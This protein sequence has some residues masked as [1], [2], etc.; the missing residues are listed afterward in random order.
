MTRVLA[1]LIA[2]ALAAPAWGQSARRPAVPPEAPRILSDI[3]SWTGVNGGRRD[4]VHTGIDIGGPDGQPIIAAADGVVLEA[5]VERC[6]GPTVAVDH[7]RAR[8]GTRLITLYGHVDQ[9]L[10]QAG[11]RVRRGQEIARLGN[12][13]HRFPCIGGVRHLHFQIGQHYRTDKGSYWGHV[14]F[15]IDGFNPVNPHLHWADGAGRVT[16]FRPGVAYPEGTLTYPLPCR[17]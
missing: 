5:T 9:M 16:C 14:Y 4:Q 8:D 3:G 15:L 17:N 11:Q 1:L 2:L 13:H 7:G 10:V 12:N 6:W